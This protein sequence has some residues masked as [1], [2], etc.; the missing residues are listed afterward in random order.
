[1]ILVPLVSLA[2]R[3]A[4]SGLHFVL[5][6][7]AASSCCIVT[8]SEPVSSYLE[9]QQEVWFRWDGDVCCRLLHLSATASLSPLG[10]HGLWRQ[11]FVSDC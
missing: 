4:R 6:A 11:K 10:G 9:V 3:A 7:P 5:A 2:T 8:K 1:M